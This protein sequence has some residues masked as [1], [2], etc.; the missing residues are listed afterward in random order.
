MY[1]L[2]L[3]MLENPFQKVDDPPA[4]RTPQE[5]VFLLCGKVVRVPK[6]PR[7]FAF[8]EKF[9]GGRA[10]GDVHALFY[11]PLPHHR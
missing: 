7:A 5:S 1:G 8:I 10:H 3:K 6:P 11:P 2:V 9:M 4:F